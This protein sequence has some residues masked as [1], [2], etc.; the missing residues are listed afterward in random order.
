MHLGGIEDVQRPVV[1]VGHVV[2]D[3]DERVDR[4]KADGDELALHPF[5]RRAVLHT[6]DEAQ[7]EG[8]AKL[9]LVAEIEGDGDRAGEVALDR[10]VLLGDHLA[11]A[12]GG[13]IAGDAGNAEAVGPVRRDRDL[14]H[15]IV[16]AGIG[17]VGGA[18]GRV[19]GQVDDAVMGIRQHQ[20]AFRA[21]HAVRFHAADDADLEVDPGA[22]NVAA[23]RREDALH[24]GAGVRRAAHDLDRIAGPGIDHAYPQPVGIRVL[25]RRDDIGDGERRELVRLALDALDLEPDHGQRLDDLVELGGR[26]QVVF[27]PGQGEL[28]DMSLTIRVRCRPWPAGKRR[29]GQAVRPPN[30]V[31]RSSGRKP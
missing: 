10:L 8:R 13:Q 25:F 7:R 4:A 9:R 3:V 31:G 15:R 22:G 28:H 30:R 5:R 24:A 11:K 18:D 14:D 16:E 2:G 20:L 21:Q 12:G 27:Q 19:L 23:G 29:S 6:L 26:L 1:G 17:R